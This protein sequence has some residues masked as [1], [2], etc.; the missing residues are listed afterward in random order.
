VWRVR[1]R[2]RA[3][4][5]MQK[6]SETSGVSLDAVGVWFRRLVSFTCQERRLASVWTSLPQGRTSVAGWQAGAVKRHKSLSDY[7]VV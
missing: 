5:H 4:E 2:A 3:S 6:G 7:A 1:I